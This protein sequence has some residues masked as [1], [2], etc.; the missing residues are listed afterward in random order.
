[1]GLGENKGNILNSEPHSTRFVVLFCLIVLVSSSVL[2]RDDFLL[3]ILT[4]NVMGQMYRPIKGMKDR[5]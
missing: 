4:L 5:I 1:M 2:N 3:F